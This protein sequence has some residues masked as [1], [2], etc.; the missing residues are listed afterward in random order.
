MWT[1]TALVV[2]AAAAPA[3]RK[4]A[5]VAV[6]VAAV[7]AN[8][9]TPLSVAAPKRRPRVVVHGYFQQRTVHRTCYP[10]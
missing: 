10:L 5:L 3:E 6:A 4:M 1:E 2:A 7:L 8:K 9:T